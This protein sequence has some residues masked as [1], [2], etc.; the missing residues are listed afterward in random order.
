MSLVVEFRKWENLEID[1]A[2]ATFKSGN[3]FGTVAGK[4]ANSVFVQLTYEF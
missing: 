2:G 1:L 3:A 4:R